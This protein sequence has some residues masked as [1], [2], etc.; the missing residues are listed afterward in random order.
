MANLQIILFEVMYL[1]LL[2][3]IKGNVKEGVFLC[4]TSELQV[5]SVGSEGVETSHL[6]SLN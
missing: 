3:A 5:A 4:I 6:F 1:F 2:L